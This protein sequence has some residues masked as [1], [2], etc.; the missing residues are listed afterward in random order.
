MEKLSNRE[1][2]ILKIIEIHA[3]IHH[4]NLLKII[5]DKGL[6][7]KKT[8][9][10]NIKSLIE[11]KR[12]DSYKYGKEKEYVI[13]DGESNEKNLKKKVST[14]IKKL[15]H[16]LEKIDDE[17]DDFDYLT[18][19]NFP[20]YLTRLLK[21][22]V[23]MKKDVIRFAKQEKLT[24]TSYFEEILQEIQT[25]AEN[26]STIDDIQNKKRSADEIMTALSRITNE[27]AE[28]TIKRSNMRT[29]KKREEL[30]HKLERMYSEKSDFQ[31]KLEAIR[32]E[33]KSMK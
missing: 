16:E 2:E 24:D 28:L 26:N 23:K 33:L 7:A 19:R 5:Q 10:R 18:K 20:Q 30:S 8:A 21:D 14:T 31:Q 4:R 1:L 12:I 13:S 27:Y 22:L 15:K 25:L 32:D 17:F 6:M 3:G 29:S 9:E 11:K